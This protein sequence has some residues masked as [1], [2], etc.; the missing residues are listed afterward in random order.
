MIRTYLRRSVASLI[1]TLVSGVAACLLAAPA[2]AQVTVKMAT[3]VPDNS[4]WALILKQMAAEWTKVSGGKVTLRL[5][6]GGT[7]GDDQNVVS[8]M[9]TGALNG[10]VL[11]AAGV[12]E[13]D[14]SVYAM[15]IPM[16]YDS[17]EEVYAVLEKMRP[18]IEASIDA[19][20]FV[21]LNWA[22]AGW[23]HFFTKK[24]VA[25]PDDLK[26]LVL[27]Q[28][29]G[30]PKSMAIWQAAG[31]NPRAGASSEL[32]SGLKTGMYEACSAP[33]QVASIMR[34]YENA[35]NMTDVNWALLLGATV[36]TKD[37][38]NKIPADIRP[39]LLKAA[40][41]AGAKLRDDVRRNGETS[42]NAMKQAGL[43]VVPVDARVKDA[44]VKAATAAYPKVKGDFVPA[45][46][47][48]EALK[49]RDEYRR[50][51]PAPKK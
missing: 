31:F 44:W 14:K 16:A 24:P 32:L 6:L 3:M 42:V 22:D 13:L 38:W 1:A 29:Q 15:S 35:R 5:Y 23:L 21:V 43:T 33:P 30:D 7:R 46:A 36:V 47:F 20:G 8:D 28:W 25:T 12:A 17:Y 41:N 11:T 51:H 4:A 18:R 48:D 49:Y 45:D 2:S 26:K 10:A 19:K 27:F 37:T 9:R 34:Y 39:A 50:Q 40:Q